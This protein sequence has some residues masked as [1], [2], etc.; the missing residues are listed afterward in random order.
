MTSIQ[1]FLLLKSQIRITVKKVLFFSIVLFLFSCS[2]DDSTVPE[3]AYDEAVFLG[4]IDWVKSFGGTGEETAQ[5][6]IHTND[7]GY[8]ILGYS[9]STDGDLNGK[10]VA[11]NDYWILKLD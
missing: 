6:V 2:D 5:S 11:V 7:G 9:Q 10:T 3:S 4:E 8:A 1:V